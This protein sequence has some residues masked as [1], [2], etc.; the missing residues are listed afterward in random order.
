[1]KKLLFISPTFYPNVYFGGTIF[2]SL[3]MCKDLS[4]IYDV[5]VLTTSNSGKN[6]NFSNKIK[7][8]HKFKINYC[9]EEI[10]NKFSINF[11]IIFF[12]LLRQNKIVY[13]NDIFSLYALVTLFASILLKKKTILAPRGTFS[14]YTLNNNNKTLKRIIIFTIKILLNKSKFLSF[15]VTSKL[16]S[17]ETKNLGF[18]NQIYLIPN[19]FDI[20]K[21]KKIFINFYKR[22]NFKKNNK[23]IKIAYFGRI[24][25]KKYFELF[26]KLSN[27]YLHD[28]NYSF[29]V[30]GENYDYDKSTLN[31]FFI[32]DN[33]H[34]LGPLHCSK[35]F[36]FILDCD[37][38]F[39]LSE[40]EN[41]GNSAFEFLI[42]NKKIIVF[43]NNIW[44]DNF[45]TFIINK[46]SEDYLNDIDLD[47]ISAIKLKDS[48]NLNIF[49]NETNYSKYLDFDN[50]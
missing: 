44:N 5:T 24:T 21:Y 17:D 6:I 22:K 1:M 16:E 42:F 19:L 31:K 46:N 30:A 10:K 14:E 50:I 23:K 13:I 34:Y 18:I 7:Y 39:F 32:N 11:F 38:L 28:Q 15:H 36:K 33:L 20:Q 47:K 41:F 45:N 9:K 35:K 37:I 40:N 2:S 12:K 43:N 8:L 4:R 27:K 25:K 48:K 26:I 3:N 49:Y 29:L